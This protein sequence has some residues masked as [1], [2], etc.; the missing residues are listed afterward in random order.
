VR[1]ADWVLVRKLEG[2]SHFVDLGIDM[3][4]KLKLVIHKQY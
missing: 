2:K 3:R 1:G 4:I